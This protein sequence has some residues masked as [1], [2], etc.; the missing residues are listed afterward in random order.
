MRRAYLDTLYKIA[1]KDER[2]F[3]VISDNG[4]IVYDTFRE[5][6]SDRLINAGIAEQNMIAMAAG[7]AERGKIPFAYTIG[8]FI[9]YRGYEFV[10]NDVCLMNQNV[11]LVGIGAGCSYSLLGAS[12]HTVFDLAALRALPNLT[13][14]SPA[15]PKEVINAT[16]AAYEICG[17]VYLR[18]GT[19]GE[20]EIYDNEAFFQVG[21]ANVLHDGS[22]LTIIGTGSIVHMLW[23]IVLKMKNEGLNIRLL[24]MHT[25]KPFDDE[26]V[27]CAIEETGGIIAVEE[28]QIIGGLGSAV[29]EVIAEYGKPIRFKRIGIEG[30]TKGYGAYEC[31]RE[32]N[33]IG[34]DR[35]MN[36]IKNMIS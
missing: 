28:H 8:A 5:N 2:V 17:P 26:S 4:A 14:L 20:K 35:I 36:E 32:M 18:L 24:N 23:E 27:R 22:D 34:A 33:K 30:F 13:I 19:S 31:V 25:I 9:A 21:K 11:K 16:R 10:M 29:S 12:H 7:L 6:F 1:E 15:S 3:A